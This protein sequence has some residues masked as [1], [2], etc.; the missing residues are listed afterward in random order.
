MLRLPAALHRGWPICGPFHTPSRYV[1]LQM[2][3]RTFAAVAGAL[4]TA[5]SMLWFVRTGDEPAQA[6]NGNFRLFAPGLTNSSAFSPIPT[7]TPT[8][9]PI[10]GGGGGADG[11]LDIFFEIEIVAREIS[12][13]GGGVVDIPI[14]ASAVARLPAPSQAPVTVSGTVTIGPHPP[15]VIGCAW[16][17]VYATSDFTMTV[18]PP[19]AGSNAITLRFEAPEWHYDVT[20]CQTGAT[21]R[22]P[23][24]GEQ[25]MLAFLGYAFPEFGPPAGSP[26]NVPEVAVAPDCIKREINVQRSVQLADVTLRIVIYEPPCLLPLP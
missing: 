23:A 20:I 22:A 15:D 25:Q 17:R 16:N 12:V 4:L 21:V 5:V 24:F 8:P 2:R 13:V 6:A 18:S 9:T 14:Y 10:G 26:I 7:P 19:P 1:E 3:L 11:A